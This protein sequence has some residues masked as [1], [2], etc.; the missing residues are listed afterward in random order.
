MFKL[1]GEVIC[2]NDCGSINGYY[3]RIF[4]YIELN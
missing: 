2:V 3:V 1:S 4:K